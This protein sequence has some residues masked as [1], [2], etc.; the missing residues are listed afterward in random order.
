MSAVAWILLAAAAAA[1][2]LVQLVY[3]SFVLAW[4]DRRTR[5]L[6]YY[7]LEPAARDRFKRTLRLHATL[8]YPILSLL[9]RF[10][11]FTFERSSFTHA[12]VAGPK[13]TCSAESFA[14]AER[15]RP[16]AH[17]IFVVT[18]M[19]CGTTWMQHLVYE[20]L[21]RGA[22]DLVE[23][24]RALY[25]V[26]PWLEGLKSVPVEAAP[27]I[28][29]ERPSRVIKTHLPTRLCPFGPTARYIYVARHPVS[30]FAS[31]ADFLATNT[32]ALGPD[33]AQLESW[34]CSEEMWWGPWPEH[35]AGWW[36]RARQSENVL[37]VHFEEM[38][39]D[40]A[41]VARRVAA[42]LGMSTLTDDEIGAVVRKCS[43][44]YMQR[45]RTTF[46]MHPPHILATHA[47]LFVRGTADRHH[48][49]PGD[50]RRRILTWCADALEDSDY[51]LERMYGSV[52][53][54]S[55]PALENR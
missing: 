48:D 5:G 3:L 46:E 25:A 50:L 36:Q 53:A 38:K 52:A 37:L 45:H 44:D 39:A 33:L 9:G 11:S 7:G 20:V 31:C 29:S 10:S 41:G 22:G 13:G 2:F 12:E 30:C 24:G 1:F 19:K 18:Q 32:G 43:F 28:G 6:A 16:A 27:L 21:Q 40:L 35:V 14:R 15:Y 54:A 23:S 4:E 42:F 8:L 55:R 47:D 17:D 49:V 26:S 34:F 51:P